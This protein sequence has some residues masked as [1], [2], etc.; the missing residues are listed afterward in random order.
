MEK[1]ATNEQISKLKELNALI[2]NNGSTAVSIGYSVHAAQILKDIDLLS[3]FSSTIGS[4]VT[5]FNIQRESYPYKN[6]VSIITNAID[7]Y[8]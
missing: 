2:N 1:K 5:I 7:Y 4:E 8:Q 6:I 3:V